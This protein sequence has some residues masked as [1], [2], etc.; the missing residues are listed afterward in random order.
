M[1]A[2]NIGVNVHYLPV[3]YLG[4]YRR[5]L[6]ATRGD[7]PVAEDAF[8]RCLTLPLHPAMSDHDVDSVAQALDKVLGAQVT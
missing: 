4:Y 2:E 3:H 1:R 7:Y 6:G 8:A 5:L